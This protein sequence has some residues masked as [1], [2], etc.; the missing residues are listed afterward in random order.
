MRLPAIRAM[1]LNK[2]VPA[3][4][5]TRADAA[6]GLNKAG[7]FSATLGALTSGSSRAATL[8]LSDLGRQL[9]VKEED[10]RLWEGLQLGDSV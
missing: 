10:K 5:S 2:L 1:R 8:E 9:G 3:V 6:A 7:L 4:V